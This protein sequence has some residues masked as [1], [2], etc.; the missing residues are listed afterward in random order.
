MMDKTVAII[1]LNW[2]GADL[3]IECLESL[4]NIAYK[5]AKILVVDNGSIDDSVERISSAFPAVH[6]FETHNNYGFAGGNNRG[7]QYANEKWD[8]EYCIFLNNDTTVDE[9]FVDSLLL[10][11][12]NERVHA[13]VPKIYYYNSPNVIWYAGGRINLW[14]GKSWHVGI[15][16]MDEGQYNE[17]NNTDYATGCCLSIRSDVF[18]KINGFSESFRMYAEDAD[19][20][21]RIRSAGGQ[22][23][24]I[25]DS[26]IWH[27]VSASVGGSLSVKKIIRKLRGNFQLLMLHAKWYQWITIVLFSPIQF[28]IGLSKYLRFR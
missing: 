13:T 9:G 6:I 24:Y 28:V 11:F 16:E 18:K 1:I 22:I 14:L 3:T 4:K 15:R 17:N 8:P 5:Q 26:K 7:F 21:L 12:E 25:P 19:L 23:M 2:N 10:P 20:S 27:K